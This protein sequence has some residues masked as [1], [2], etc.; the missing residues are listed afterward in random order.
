MDRWQRQNRA[1][2]WGGYIWT[3]CGAAWLVLGIQFDIPEAFI[4]GLL[5][6]GMAYLFNRVA[7]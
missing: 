1:L 2:K 6:C 7:S 5:C 3:G 4:V